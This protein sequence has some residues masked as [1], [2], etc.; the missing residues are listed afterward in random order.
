MYICMYYNVHIQGLREIPKL[1]GPSPQTPAPCGDASETSGVASERKG[2][3]RGLLRG[4]GVV[5][6]APFRVPLKGS[7]GFRV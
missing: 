6:R 1:R 3:G 2:Q 4:S 7:R 5:I